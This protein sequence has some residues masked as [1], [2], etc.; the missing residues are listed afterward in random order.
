MH[1]TSFLGQGLDGGI[2]ATSAGIA[3]KPARST[4]KQPTIY[5]DAT[6][7]EVGFQPF[8]LPSLMN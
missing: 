2:L 7:V 6:W 3:A 1:I 4:K 8:T 5:Q